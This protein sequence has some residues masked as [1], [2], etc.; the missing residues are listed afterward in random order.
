MSECSTCRVL[1]KSV[2]VKA[3][4][5]ESY[6]FFQQACTSITLSGQIIF[7]PSYVSSIKNVFLNLYKINIQIQRLI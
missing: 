4:E 2:V 7:N 1:M 6:F 5:S 3:E